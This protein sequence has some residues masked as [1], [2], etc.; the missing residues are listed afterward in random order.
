M[1]RGGALGRSL[2]HVGEALKYGIGILSKE[3]QG[4]LHPFGPVKT[5]KKVLC[6]NQ[7]VGSH[8]TRSA[9]TLTLDS[10]LQNGKK[11]TFVV[12]KP[13]I[14]GTSL[15]PHKVKEAVMMSVLTVDQSKPVYEYL[16]SSSVTPRVFSIRKTTSGLLTP[17]R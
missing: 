2:G 6:M 9:G 12:D 5:L 1:L 11:Y 8:Q 14:C 16:H 17:A 3:G 15:Q 10:S 7:E 4:H 13:L